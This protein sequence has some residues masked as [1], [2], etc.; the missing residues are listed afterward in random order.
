MAHRPLI[1]SGE[2]PMTEDFC[3]GWKWQ[4]ESVERLAAMAYGDGTTAISGFEVSAGTGLNLY[5]NPGSILLPGVV[6]TATYGPLAADTAP[7]LGQYTLDGA[8]T[9]SVPGQGTFFVYVAPVDQ[10]DL[11]VSLPFYN[12]SNPAVTL[13]GQANN[14]LALPS[15]RAKVATVGVGTSVPSGSYTVATV[16]VPNGATQITS[17]MISAAT[18]ATAGPIYPTIPQLALGRLVGVQQFVSTGIYTPTPGARLARIRMV[19]GGAAGGGTNGAG[20]NTAAAAGSGG[21]GGGYLELLLNISGLSSTV[22][23][24]VGAGG[25]PVSANNGGNGGQSSFGAYAI[26]LGGTGGQAMYAVA[27]GNSQQAG[28]GLGGGTTIVNGLPG[29]VMVSKAGGTGLNGL[30]LPFTNGTRGLAISG[31]GGNSEMGTG[32]GNTN[33]GNGGSPSGYGAGGSGS[34][35]VDGNN[36]SG[37]PGG[38]GYVVIEEIS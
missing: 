34:A 36:Y 23:V 24:S 10:D 1:Y 19:G 6:D 25:T 17:G 2:I 29:T 11:P 9:V 26:C 15:R 33:G 18:V 4:M 38:G 37:G 30:V 14:G 31:M 7:I 35:S 16:T 20:V 5:V 32:S 13:N 22:S 28:Q 27:A 21:G 3:Q 12:A 8:A